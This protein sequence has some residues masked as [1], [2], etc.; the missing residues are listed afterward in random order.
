MTS[1][2]VLKL[3]SAQATTR[4]TWLSIGERMSVIDAG[5][6]ARRIVS[7]FSTRESPSALIP[8]RT[9][10]AAISGEPSVA[11]VTPVTEMPRTA[12]RSTSVRAL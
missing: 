6:R 11:F 12:S 8:A 4:A 9:K 7:I 10:T 1:N 3:M 2:S 5:K